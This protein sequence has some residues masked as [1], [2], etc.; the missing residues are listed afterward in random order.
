MKY[1]QLGLALGLPVGELETIKT[2]FPHN[3]DQALTEMLL[4]WLRQKY[5]TVSHGCPTWQGL[6]RAVINQTHGNN[7]ALA[8]DIASN[9]HKQSKDL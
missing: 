2:G 4:L 7:Y 1:Y 5:D 8:M 3:I 9:H 6:V